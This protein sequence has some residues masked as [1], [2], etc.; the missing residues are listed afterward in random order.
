[1]KVKWM[2]VDNEKREGA[3]NASASPILGS[4]QISPVV[5]SSSVEGGEPCK[6]SAGLFAFVAQTKAPP[7]SEKVPLEAFGSQW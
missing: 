7:Q 6:Q 4:S 2:G 5:L 3:A 1:M